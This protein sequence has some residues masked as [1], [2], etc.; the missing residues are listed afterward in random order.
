M[1]RIYKL[2]FFFLLTTIL[3]YP[4]KHRP[5]EGMYPLSDISGINLK[6]AGLKISPKDIYNPGKVSLID[7]LVRLGGCTG[8]FVSSNGLIL[9]NHHC[10][11]SFVQ[12]ASSLE[13]NYLE[14]GFTS[15]KREEEIPAEGLTC[16]ITES[17]KDVSKEILEA[18]E[19]GNNPLERMDLISAKIKEIIAQEEKEH[20]EIKAEVSEMFKGEKYV[21]FRYLNITDIRL[22]YAPPRS[23][24]EFGGESDNWI[25][26]RHTGDFSF[27]R[28]Y[29][30]KDGKPAPY[31]KDNVPY[32]PK[33]YLHI[34]A[35]GVDEGDFVFILGYPG[36]T[37]R[38]QPS[39]YIEFQKEYQLPYIADF[40]KWM[41]NY[42]LEEGKN[43]PSFALEISSKIKGLAN[44]MKNYEGKL[45]GIARTNLLNNME[46]EEEGLYQY[47]NSNKELSSK[48]GSLKNDI[49]DVYKEVFAN[50]RISMFL[51][52][53]SR[54]VNLYRLSELL[55]DKA[56]KKGKEDLKQV[57][58]LFKSLRI[59]DDKNILTKLV[60]DALGFNEFNDIEFFKNLKSK[61]KGS[62]A[63]AL[64][65]NSIL[66][67]S[68]LVNKEKYLEYYNSSSISQNDSFI[69][70]VKA[71]KSL[72]EL[73]RKEGKI[74][75]GKL[76][77]YQAQLFDVKRSYMKKSFIPDAN[78]TLR[79]TY[80]YIKGYSPA[81]AVY[82]SPFTSLKG[83]VEKGKEGGD[84]KIYP[85]LVEL[86]NKKDFGKYKSKKLNDVPVALLYNT[87]T[88]GG[89]S[90]SPVMNAS[91]ELIGLNFDRTYEAT[92]NDYTWS[93]DYSR[94][95]GVDIR[96]ILWNVEKLGGA[97]NLIKEL[98][99][100]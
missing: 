59:N 100:K 45:Q 19:K 40:Y 6:A 21:L 38:N 16:R 94:S 85:K 58:E 34:N 8:S 20:S 24:G 73:K 64:F 79:L 57:E 93:P 84:Y 1:R 7:A 39:Q 30:G 97:Q 65:V 46:T 68:E 80:G 87:D 4:S 54:N 9:T 51:S 92:I 11:F 43:D 69:K 96:Y 15:M 78:S 60:G 77:I 56:D 36:T 76:N 70:F 26:P 37:F 10:A 49:N 31:S 48:Y 27:V 41:I 25:W 14:N 95:I 13:N 32:N 5:D 17:Y 62:D 55:I 12:K 35:A 99:V 67:N 86:Y 2:I 22:V 72:D 61:Y 71:M 33:E 74:R 29:V 88:S 52:Q 3:I 81:D 28:A 50:G 82:Y 90:G 23:I 98:G 47:I 83:V 44:T 18:A 75:E 63:A 53:L 42:Y 89:N 66:T 91:G